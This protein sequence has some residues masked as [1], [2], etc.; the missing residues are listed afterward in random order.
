MDV[1]SNNRYDEMTGKAEAVNEYQLKEQFMPFTGM[2]RHERRRQAKFDRQATKRALH[3]Q[4]KREARLMSKSERTPDPISG[5]MDSSTATEEVWVMGQMM[6]IRNNHATAAAYFKDNHSG[7]KILIQPGETVTLA[8]HIYK[9]IK[10]MMDKHPHLS[11]MTEAMHKQDQ[12][13]R[14]QQAEKEP[15][16]EPKQ[17]APQDPESDEDEALEAA[18]GEA[19][20]ELAALE[21]EQEAEAE[22]AEQEEALG[23]MAQKADP[24]KSADDQPRKGRRKGGK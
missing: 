17:E 1:D 11:I 9:H 20:A 22:Q 14:A 4:E 18:A 7:A 15:E 8:D 23:A 19:L 24:E 16:K 5:S 6:H 21:A 2:N 3:D 10:H 13:N 12:A